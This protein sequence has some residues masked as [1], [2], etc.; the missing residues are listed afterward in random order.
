MVVMFFVVVVG[1]GVVALGVVGLGVVGLGVVGLGVVG[2][3]VAG[4]GGD[5]VGAGVVSR[6]VG[7]GGGGGVVIGGVV[8]TKPT[9]QSLFPP[10]GKNKVTSYKANGSLATSRFSSVAN[11]LQE[12]LACGLAC[13]IPGALTV[14]GT[15]TVVLDSRRSCAGK[16]R[17]GGLPTAF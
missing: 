7:D 14:K 17:R 4:G 11:T 16:R 15:W 13:E 2:L 8:V 12:R 5:G 9:L 10:T 3:G 1:L 6:V